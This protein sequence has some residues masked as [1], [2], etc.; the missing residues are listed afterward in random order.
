M[1]DTDRFIVDRRNSGATW[2]EIAEDLR[3]FHRSGSMT[4]RQAYDFARNC[5]RRHFQGK[6]KLRKKVAPKKPAKD[7]EIE[8]IK[9]E[10]RYTNLMPELFVPGYDSKHIRIGIVSDTH[11]GSKYAQY[12]A[13]EDFYD[14]C[15]SFGITDIYH[16][17]D[18]DDGSENMHPGV[19]YEHHC[20]GATEHIRNIVE[21]YPKRE[22]VTTHFITGNHDN[23]HMKNAGLIVGEEVALRRPDMHYLGRDVAIIQL[24]PHC[25]ME[26]RHPGDGSSYAISYK[27]QKIVEAYPGG[28]KPNI[29]V[30]GHYHKA[31]WMMHRNVHILMAGAFCGTTPFMQS[32]A[33][34]SVVG[35]WVLDIDIKPDGTIERLTPTFYPYYSEAQG[36]WERLA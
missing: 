30:I 11:F 24:A 36:D 13:L 32:K 22:G 31:L 21:H 19:M 16:A 6:A 12:S 4:H 23:S 18:I 28:K 3:G 2:D 8:R 9:Q 35:G 27:A 26:L 33:L 5:Y 10:G 14:R 29:L 17:G 15:Q 34:T 25:T 7:P 20:I 1:T